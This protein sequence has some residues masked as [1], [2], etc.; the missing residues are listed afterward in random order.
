VRDTRYRRGWYVPLLPSGVLTDRIGWAL[1]LL[2]PENLSYASTAQTVGLTAG[3]FLTSTIFLAF[4]SKEFANRYFRTVPLETGLVSLGGALAFSGWMYLIVTV[5]LGVL[6][7]ED[8]TRNEDGIWDTYKVMVEI[9]KKPN[10]LSLIFV[11]LIAKIGF[12]ANDGATAL[13]LIDKGFGQDNLSLVVLIDF[14]FE[15]GLGYY[16][17]KWSSVY[18][19]MQLW[20]WAFMGRLG[21]AML[22]QF[23]VSIFPAGPDVPLWY[24]GTVILSHVYSTFTNTIMF[25]A[26]AAFHAKIA[27]PVY[28]GTYMT[29]L[30]T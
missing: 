16:V 1:T 11:H 23:I 5:G 15:I 10:I 7:R 29:L 2:S 19:P 28:G 22:A 6:K 3:Q 27:D 12:Q 20:G 8:P 26:V 18:P 14:P 9:L 30:A 4:N 21:A 17:G 13:K 25:V 24:L